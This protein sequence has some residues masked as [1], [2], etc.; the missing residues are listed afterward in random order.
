MKNAEEISHSWLL[1]FQSADIGAMWNWNFQKILKLGHQAFSFPVKQIIN[2]S[3]S[4]Y[5]QNDSKEQD[6]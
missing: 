6:I 3:L 5:N 1:S 4:L 2:K